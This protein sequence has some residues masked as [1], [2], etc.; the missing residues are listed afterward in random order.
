MKVLII[1]DEKSLARLM[2]VELSLQGK[3]VEV[4][5]DGKSGLIAALEGGADLVLLD[6]MLPDLE[7]IEVCRILRSKGSTVPII[8]ITAKQGVSYE[9]EGLHVGA[10]DYITKPFDMEQLLARMEAVLRRTRRMEEGSAKIVHGQLV[11]DTEERRVSVKGKQ[12][13]LTRK[14][15]DILLILLQN[16]GRIVTKEQILEKVWGSNI[17]LEE[18]VL[19]VHIASIRSKLRGSY[20]ENVRGIGYMIPRYDET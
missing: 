16:R 12:V 1:E 7:G 3:E 11:M 5:H 15:Y 6:W 17:H 13:H 10:D 8:M 4:R 20:I 9:V 2:E 14:E 18:G 19:P